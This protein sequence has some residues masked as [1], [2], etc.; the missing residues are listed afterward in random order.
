MC[1]RDRGIPCGRV[2][3]QNCVT[4]PQ[5]PVRIRIRR[6][7]VCSVHCPGKR[8]E[9]DVASGKIT[10][11]EIRDEPLTRVIHPLKPPILSPGKHAQPRGHVDAMGPIEVPE[12][13]PKG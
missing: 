6:K 10:T 13:S 11:S 8:I 3:L 7:V 12:L 4:T 9:I 1:I 5:E 2:I